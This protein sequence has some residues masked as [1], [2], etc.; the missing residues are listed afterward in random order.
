MSFPKC[1]LVMVWELGGVVPMMIES[2]DQADAYDAVGGAEG[3]IGPKKARRHVFPYLLIARL[4]VQ[5][6]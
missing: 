5:L 1:H 4:V 2:S 6:P 3:S